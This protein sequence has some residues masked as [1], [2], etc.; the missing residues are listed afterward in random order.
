M[1]I[2]LIISGL[3]LATAG[4]ILALKK[5][6]L[7]CFANSDT[8]DITTI[9]GKDSHSAKSDGPE[10]TVNPAFEGN[11]ALN[12]PGLNKSLNNNQRQGVRGNAQQWNAQVWH[13]GEANGN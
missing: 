8:A 2:V 4:G 5:E 7:L 10:G 1:K 11:M 3:G 12:P 9:K 13:S 6:R